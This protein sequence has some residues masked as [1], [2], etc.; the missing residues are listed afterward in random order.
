M[1]ETTEEEVEQE[2]EQATDTSSPEESVEA[3]DFKSPNRVPKEQQENLS[4]I[5]ESYAHAI[6]INLSAFLRSEAHAHLAEVEQVSFQEYLM[7]LSNP[8]C[9]ATFD[10]QPLSGH[11]VIEVNAAL[12]FTVIDKMLGGEGAPPTN[13]ETRNFT[14]IEVS[15]AR[16]LLNMLLTHLSQS[17]T[18]ILTIAFGLKDTQTN[19][20][21]I[22]AISP[23]E[24][25]VTASIKMTV[26]ETSG[27]MTICIPYAT[28]EPIAGK[29]R[30]DQVNKF[31]S[32]QPEDV[33]T[34]HRRNFNQMPFEVTALL[35]SL[36]ISMEELLRLQEGDILDTGHR[37]KEPIEIRVAGQAKFL[38]SPGLVGRHR[39]VTIQN[40]IGKE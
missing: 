17:W 19:P 14:D 15:V 21:F 22:R 8:T 11:G 36:D 34:A 28:L 5:F 30:N 38:A 16:K 23:R 33:M 40:E 1:A 24:P 27:L 4:L 37:A 25:C 26:G 18:H 20:A 6:T 32:K 3:Y 12:V 10:M 13:Q 29:L 31:K 9:V 2:N 35:G 39:G 7:S